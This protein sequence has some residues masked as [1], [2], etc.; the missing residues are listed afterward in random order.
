MPTMQDN[1]INVPNVPLAANILA[2][3]IKRP[4]I[5]SEKKEPKIIRLQFHH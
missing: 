2:N 4:L 3:S 1:K 5:P